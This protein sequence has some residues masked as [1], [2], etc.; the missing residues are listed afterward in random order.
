MKIIWSLFFL[1]LGCSQLV[2]CERCQVIKQDHK[3]ALKTL[4]VVIKELKEEDV[5]ESLTD[6]QLS[7]YLLF[8]HKL[9]KKLEILRKEARRGF[10]IRF[11]STLP[12]KQFPDDDACERCWQS[13]AGGRKHPNPSYVLAK[14][15]DKRLVYICPAYFEYKDKERVDS[16]IHELSHLFLKAGHDHWREAEKEKDPFI[17]LD[18]AYFFG[19]FSREGETIKETVHKQIKWIIAV[20]KS[21]F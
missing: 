11:M 7:Q 2:A 8:K 15:R 14:D 4:T 5:D 16:L 20:I 13:G 19:Q 12:D 9:I 6:K 18:S 3:Q 17:L 21:A 1:L 10:T